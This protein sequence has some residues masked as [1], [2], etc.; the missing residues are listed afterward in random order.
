MLFQAFHVVHMLDK[1]LYGGVQAFSYTRR[2]VFVYAGTHDNAVLCICVVLSV[3]LQ[4]L[5]SEDEQ[6]GQAMSYDTDKQGYCRVSSL[7]P[8][9]V[10]FTR[11]CHPLSTA[12]ERER[13]VTYPQSVSVSCLHSEG[14]IHT[15]TC[16]HRVM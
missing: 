3:L 10:C 9:R 4:V 12:T 5:S 14:Q 7:W 6:Q 11:S 16:T 2:L 8:G 1:I 15:H 13:A